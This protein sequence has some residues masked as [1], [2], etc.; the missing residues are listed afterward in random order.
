MHL[1]NVGLDW[2]PSGGNYFSTLIKVYTCI[3]G[4]E[5]GKKKYRYVFPMASEGARA[6][7]RGLGHSPQWGPGAK[8]L[9]GESGGS[10]LVGY[11]T[12]LKI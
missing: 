4:L 8:P 2:L 12:D 7:T 10:Q 1:T 6:Y 11:N 9:V 5:G 3:A